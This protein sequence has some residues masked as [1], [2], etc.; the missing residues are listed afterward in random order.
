MCLGPL[1]HNSVTQAPKSLL[2]CIFPGAKHGFSAFS[3]S[4][5]GEC[6]PQGRGQREAQHRFPT[7]SGAFMP[8]LFF[9]RPLGKVFAF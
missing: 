7:L 1:I 4:R 8:L 6:P 2:I 9:S 3:S 5:I